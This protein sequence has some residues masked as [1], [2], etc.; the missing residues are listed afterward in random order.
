VFCLSRTSFPLPLILR[1]FYKNMPIPAVYL[2]LQKTFHSLTVPPSEMRRARQFLVT[3][4]FL[5]GCGVQQP[6]QLVTQPG[7]SLSDYKVLAV[8]PISNETGQNYDFDFVGAFTED[9]SSAL[10]SQGYHVA[11]ASSAP[12]GSLLVRCRVLAYEPGNAFERYMLPGTGETEVTVATSLVDKKTNEVLGGISTSKEVMVGAFGAPGAYKS[13]FEAVSQDI[14]VSIDRKI[15]GESAPSTYTARNFYMS[16]ESSARVD[17]EVKLY[18]PSELASVKYFT[19]TDAQSRSCRQKI[20]DPPASQENALA[21]MKLQASSIGANGIT[22]LTCQDESSAS[23]L[24]QNCFS[25]VTCSGS[26]I[27]VKVPPTP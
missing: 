2:S 3:F 19:I 11:S 16:P 9:L 6:P 27:K 5:C 18:E 23:A 24:S 10:R 26:L 4:V 1:L 12:D 8:A 14:A 7:I 22:N 25:V 21:Q 13:V 17:S 15:K 20:W